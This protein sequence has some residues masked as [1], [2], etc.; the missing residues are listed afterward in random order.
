MVI[1]HVKREEMNSSEMKSYGVDK[2]KKGSIIM[3]ESNDD[4]KSQAVP[5]LLDKID[6]TVIPPIRKVDRESVAYKKLS[7]AIQ[8]DGQL[9]P[10]TV[11][12][13][14][15]G[16]RQDTEAEYGIIDGHHRFAIAGDKNEP[17]ILATVVDDPPE[18]ERK[19]RDTVMAYRMNESS[20]QMTSVEKGKVIDDLMKITDKKPKEIGE[21]VFGL[22][23]AMSYRLLNAYKKSLGENTIEKPREMDWASFTQALDKLPKAQD[24]ISEDKRESQLEAIKTVQ[25]QLRYLARDL[26]RD[27]N[28][29]TKNKP[30][31]ENNN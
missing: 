29:A 11:R 5:I 16:E 26:A 1:L 21:E 19:Y 8:K 30:V 9:H 18:E 13:L 25:Q 10:I 4:T 2:Y 6:G 12:K 22:K 27:D 24:A 14:T 17:S 28:S 31:D 7:H 23:R 3:N 20:K 15:E